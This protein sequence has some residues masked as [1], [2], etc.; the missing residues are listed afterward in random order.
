MATVY[1]AA[2]PE[3]RPPGRAEGAAARARRRRSAP[4]GSCARS[5]I[6]ARLQHPHILTAPRLGRS[7]RAPLLRHALRRGGVAPGPARPGGA[8]RRSTTRVRIARE[9]A[10]A[11]AYAH[12]ARRGA[13]GHQAREHPARRR[14]RRWWPTSASPGRSTPRAATELTETG[15]AARHAGLHEPGAGRGQRGRWTAGATSTRSA[16]CS[17]RCSPASRPSPGRR[18]QAIL[19][20]HAVDPVPRLR[21]V[22]Q[23]VPRG[24]E[25]GNDA[26]RWPRCRRIASPGL[27]SLPR[28]LPNRIPNH[29]WVGA[30]LGWFSAGSWW[31]SWHWHR[32]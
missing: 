31:D 7:R 3:A 18:R 30:S 16:A 20:R 32:Y 27:P 29:Y 26:R 19:A 23:T 8:A 12:A 21:T 25:S 10:D 22:R 24:L 9:V 14:T 2:G 11:L 4:S 28:R 17:T 13:P 15:L 6:A 1:L 5:Q